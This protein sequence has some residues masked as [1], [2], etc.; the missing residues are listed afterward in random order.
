MAIRDLTGCRFGMLVALEA[1][2]ERQ[3]ECVVWRCRCD[4]GKEIFVSSN[5]LRQQRITSCGCTPKQKSKRNVYGEDLT[6]VQFGRWTVLYRN[7]KQE[8]PDLLDVP[9]RCGTERAVAAYCL[10]SGSSRSC[11]CL[12]KLNANVRLDIANRR[13]GRLVA[14]FPT[15]KRSQGGSVYWH[16]RCDCGN[17]VDVTD[18]ALISGGWK[19]CGCLKKEIQD[20]LCKSVQIIDHTAVEWLENRKHRRDNTT[21][22]RGRI[23]HQKQSLLCRDWLQTAQLLPG[24]LRY[25]GRS[26]RSASGCRASGARWLC[27]RVSG[28]AAQSRNCPR[29]CSGSSLCF[30]CP[31]G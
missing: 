11:G 6:G 23:P 26:D 8:E 7:R 15:E 5:K 22:F 17:E 31:E 12:R 14:L 24:A 3:D 25:A 9:M 10:K 4:C 20:N 16:C 27:C 29:I 2:A 28:M 18:G 21:G 13:F 19:S 30:R 1:T